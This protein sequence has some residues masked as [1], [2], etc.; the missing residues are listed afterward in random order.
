L[1]GQEGSAVRKATK[2]ARKANVTLEVGNWLTRH[3]YIPFTSMT[4]MYWR[5]LETKTTGTCAMN[6]SVYK[7]IR[8]SLPCEMPSCA[9]DDKLPSKAMLRAVGRN[10]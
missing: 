4:L 3:V 10:T 5:V 7:N 1:L 8:S 6:A 9:A 2:V